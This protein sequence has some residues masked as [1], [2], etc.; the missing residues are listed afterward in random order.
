MQNKFLITVLT[1]VGL[2]FGLL[3]FLLC[4]FPLGTID[5][6]PA[7][8]GL[9]LGIISF[10]ITKKTAFRRKLILLV[11]IISALAI[12]IS[13][14]SEIFIKNKVAEDQKFEEKIEQSEQES[15]EDLEEAFKDLE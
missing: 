2:I 5:I 4:F 3:G 9:L 14:L 8:I 6:V 12:I 11:L 1:S 7:T 10:L 15:V 13:V